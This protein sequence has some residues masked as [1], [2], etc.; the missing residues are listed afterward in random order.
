MKHFVAGLSAD[1]F[2]RPTTEQKLRHT[3]GDVDQKHG[4]FLLLLDDAS[5]QKLENGHGRESP[6]GHDGPLPD[7]FREDAA[8]AEPQRRW[9]TLQPT[10]GAARR[11][12][13][14]HLTDNT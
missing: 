10:G 14:D 12:G 5:Q 11:H 13:V 8:C 9:I 7:N 4:L 6:D 3:S 1:L 2:L